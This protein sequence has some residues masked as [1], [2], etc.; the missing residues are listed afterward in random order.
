M[1]YTCSESNGQVVLNVFATGDS[2]PQEFENTCDAVGVYE[3]STDS[4][5]GQKWVT[6]KH[7]GERVEKFRV[8]F[9]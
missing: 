2:E 4:Y 1:R 3:A 6:V 5:E 8:D 9:R 7:Q